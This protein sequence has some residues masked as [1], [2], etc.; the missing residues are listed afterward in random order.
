MIGFFSAIA[1]KDAGRKI[2]EFRMQPLAI[3][4]A[5]DVI[6]HV[7]FGFRVVRVISLP[8]TLHLHNQ[9]ESFS[10]GVILTND[11]AA[12][13]ADKAMFSEQGLILLARILDRRGRNGLSVLQLVGALG[14]PC[15][16]P[17]RPK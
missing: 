5:S 10:D 12:H 9:E 16:K 15:A 2:A 14:S 11:F 4:E 3:V 6:G 7:K 13:A 8:D 1:L 17:R